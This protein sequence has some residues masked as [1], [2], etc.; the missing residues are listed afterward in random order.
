MKAEGLSSMTPPA[1]V[2][3][4]NTDTSSDSDEEESKEDVSKVTV[5]FHGEQ[6]LSAVLLPRVTASLPLSVNID[7]SD[8]GPL[9]RH[10]AQVFPD[11]IPLFVINIFIPSCSFSSASILSSLLFLFRLSSYPPQ[12][13][14]TEPSSDP[15]DVTFSYQAP[16]DLSIWSVPL[17]PLLL[18]SRGPYC[19]DCMNL[20]Y[21]SGRFRT[22]T[23]LYL[24]LPRRAVPYP[25]GLFSVQRLTHS[26][27]R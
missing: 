15:E 6:S 22:A 4:E 9:V 24:H 3:R 26:T 18:I 19:F 25:L 10:P 13:M 21:S 16:A 23:P 12:F 20:F 1:E 11:V 5:A 14:E 2:I 8:L 7:E 17:K 27:F